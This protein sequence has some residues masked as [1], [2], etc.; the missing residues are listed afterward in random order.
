M[1]PANLTLEGERVK[2]LPMEA[3]H[4]PE[5]YA[6]STEEIWT[7]LPMKVSRLEQMERLV[8]EAL[9]HKESGE[10]FPFVVYD[11]MLNKLVGSTRCLTLNASNRNVEIGWTWYAPEVWRTRVNTE[12]KYLLLTYGFET[13]NLV[14]VQLKADIRNDRSNRAIRRIGAVPEG[15][16]RQDRILPDGYI[17]NSKLYSIID[18]EWEGVKSILEGYLSR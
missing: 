14:R 9:R 17:R 3:R 8:E 1:I 10:D 2:L 11:K 13:L 12:C 15:V 6:C 18:S 5:L 16:L 7:Y 4:A